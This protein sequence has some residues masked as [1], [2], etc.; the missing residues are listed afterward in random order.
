VAEAGGRA[1]G[2]AQVSGAVWEALARA[3]AHGPRPQWAAPRVRQ[4]GAAQLDQLEPG[5][6]WAGPAPRLDLPAAPTP[7]TELVAQ[8]TDGIC[9]VVCVYE[10][11][12]FNAIFCPTL[13]YKRLSIATPSDFASEVRPFVAARSF[14]P[15]LQPSRRVA[16]QFWG[17]EATRAS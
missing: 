4:R 15:Q 2:L 14:A 9:E 1:R 13:K 16:A 5:V 3:A 17:S 8:Q 7:P 12:L 11:V 10:D 6:Q